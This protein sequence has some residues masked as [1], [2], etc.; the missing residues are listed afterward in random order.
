MRQPL[1]H[2]QSSSESEQDIGGMSSDSNQGLQQGGGDAMR[3]SGSVS[4]VTGM[5][6]LSVTRSAPVEYGSGSGSASSLA[7]PVPVPIS[8]DSSA[9]GRRGSGMTDESSDADGRIPVPD[10]RSGGNSGQ[11]AVNNYSNSG[12]LAIA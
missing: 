2:Y 10:G 9:N 12:V 3:D 11:Q 8:S 7:G 6:R 5:S 4:A 1:V